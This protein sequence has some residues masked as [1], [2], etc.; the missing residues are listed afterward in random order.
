VSLE[1][2]ADYM[3][4]DHA[5][6]DAPNGSYS[7]KFIQDSVQ[8][9]QRQIMDRYLIGSRPIDVHESGSPR[10]ATS[11]NAMRRPNVSK[12]SRNPFTAGDD[13]ILVAWVLRHEREGYA[14]A[15]NEMYKTLAAE[16]CSR[17]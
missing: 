8:N 7:W 11:P 4:A 10:G 16:V 1:K 14:A 13:R 15:G 3:I 9:G 17:L 5:R 2:L 6:K 12:A